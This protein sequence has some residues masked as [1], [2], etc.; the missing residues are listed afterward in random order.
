MNRTFSKDEE[1]IPK[2]YMKK[3]STSL[4]INEMQIKTK[5]RFYLTPVRMNGYDKES[6]QQ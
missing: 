1:Q 5:L 6:K 2:K 4:A 3:C